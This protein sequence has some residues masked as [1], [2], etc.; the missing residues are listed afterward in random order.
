M[1]TSE[2]VYT[3]RLLNSLWLFWGAIQHS[4]NIRTR[5]SRRVRRDAL[6]YP[7]YPLSRIL[8]PSSTNF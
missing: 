5:M 8:L 7:Y 6:Q 2:C 3:F 1:P 4:D